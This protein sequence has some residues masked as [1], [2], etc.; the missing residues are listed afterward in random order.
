MLSR[1]YTDFLPCTF[2]AIDSWDRDR[3]KGD[4]LI[5]HPH[6]ENKCVL[7]FLTHVPQD[8]VDRPD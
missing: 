7:F 2:K 1:G 5:F 8:I 6:G 3:K 4:A